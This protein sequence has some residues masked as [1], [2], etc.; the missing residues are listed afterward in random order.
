MQPLPPLVRSP[1]VDYCIAA[2]STTVGLLAT[3]GLISNG[4]E[5]T[6]SGI[7]AVLIP[8]VYL[9]VMGVYRSVHLHAAAKVQAAALTSTST[10]GGAQVGQ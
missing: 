1:L 10:A 4:W 9:A 5:R 2:V 3:Q 8:L 7:A 6:I